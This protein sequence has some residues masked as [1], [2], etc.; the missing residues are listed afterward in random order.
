MKIK[1][2]RQNKAKILRFDEEVCIK[3][4]WGDIIFTKVFIINEESSK[5]D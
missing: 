2:Q 1:V 3:F 4:L 5:N